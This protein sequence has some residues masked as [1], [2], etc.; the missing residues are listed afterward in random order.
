[1]RMC[2]VLLRERSVVIR[3]V[4]LE[5]EGRDAQDSVYRIIISLNV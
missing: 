3:V 4:I 1:M 2:N 5:R